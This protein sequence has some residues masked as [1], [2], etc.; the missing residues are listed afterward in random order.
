MFNGINKGINKMKNKLK[1]LAV[2]ALTAMA[3]GNASAASQKLW[4]AGASGDFTWLRHSDMGGGANLRLGY[5]FPPASYGD[6]RLEAEAGYHGADGDTG[7]SNTHYF[8]YMGNLYYDFPNTYALSNSGW[9]VSPYIG[10]GL[11]MASVRY[12]NSSNNFTSTFHHHDNTFAWQ[13]MAG[14]SLT[15]TS[16]PNIDWTIGYRYLGTDEHNIHANNAEIG[17]RY[18]F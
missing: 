3:A 5:Q 10:G 1:F 16:M 11:G 12:G 6:L 14:L 7:Y 18:H 9:S 4:Y 2:V 8:T 15:S 17:L 13:G